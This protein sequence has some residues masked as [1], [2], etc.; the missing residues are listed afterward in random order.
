MKY[1]YK[2]KIKSYKFLV[3]NYILYFN[4]PSNLLGIL[5]PHPSHFNFLASISYKFNC[6]SLL[7]RVSVPKL[8]PPYSKKKRILTPV[9]LF[10]FIATLWCWLV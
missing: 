4:T 6:I 3:I 7:T 9:F 1:F 5:L 10:V 8:S 2:P